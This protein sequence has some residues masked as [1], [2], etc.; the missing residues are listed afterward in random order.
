[1]IINLNGNL[2]SRLEAKISIFDH[3]FLY[4]AS[5]YETIRTYGGKPFQLQNHFKRLENSARGIQIALPFDFEEFR[6]QLSITLA[7]SESAESAIRIIVTRGAGD[8][9]Y[10]PT[11][12]GPPA[13]I[14][15][16][17]PLPPVP[18]EIYE[19][20]V[21][22]A[23]VSVRRNLPEALD[24]AVK[25][26]NLLNQMLAWNEANTRN[27]YEALML[28]YRG[29]LTECT[30]CNIFLV[31]NKILRTPALECGILAGVTRQ[32]I[33]EIASESGMVAEETVLYPEDLYGAEEAFLTVTSREVIPVV[34]CDEHVIGNGFP[35]TTTR[36]L[37][38]KYRQK[39]REITEK[40]TG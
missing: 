21:I 11:R 19:K 24:P 22:L 12:L 2:V 6:R 10:A 29:E 20:G 31:R 39:V 33:L 18:P 5:I 40:E 37:H 30:M 16:V 26:G 7:K 17:S 32:M 13:Y 8:P 36:S 34:R 1:M 14:F 38:L 35:G 9:G 28:N 25:S 23:L 27:A 3:G 15:L 4:G